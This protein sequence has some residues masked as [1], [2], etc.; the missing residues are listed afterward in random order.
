MQLFYVQYNKTHMCVLVSCGLG[1]MAYLSHWSEVLHQIGQIE[2][3]APTVGTATKQVI[4]PLL[5]YATFLN[6]TRENCKNKCTSLGCLNNKIT[7]T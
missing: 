3:H 7:T 2:Q 1:Y 4:L 6:C 5:S